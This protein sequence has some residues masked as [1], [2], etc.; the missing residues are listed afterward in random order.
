MNKE[1][2]IAELAGKNFS[3]NT[4]NAFR[5]VDRE[6]FIPD[7][8]KDSAYEDI[9]LP[10]GWEQTISQPQ[11]IAFMLDL[12]ELKDKQKIMEIGSGSGYVQELIANICPRSEIYGVEIIP[13]LIEYAKERLREIN[14]VKILPADRKKPGLPDKAPFDRILV[15]AAAGKLPEDLL[16]QLND[17]GIL[18]CPVSNYIIKIKKSDGRIL[19]EEYPGFSFVKLL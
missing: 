17:P 19:C 1:E 10:I 12:L 14:N 9:A 8:Y 4:L 3:D 18:V 11:T 2:L 5:S 6:K 15:S 7:E 16:I 13:E